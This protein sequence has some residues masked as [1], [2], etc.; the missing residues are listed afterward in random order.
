[1][2]LL[3]L[4]CGS[5]AHAKYLADYGYQITGVERSDSMIKMANAKNINGFNV[6]QGDITSFELPAKY[7]A[8]I[9]LF[10]VISYLTTNE[11]IKQCFEN[12]HAHLKDEGIFIF[13]VW[14]TP[15]VYFQKPETRIRRMENDACEITRIA[16]SD[17]N[18]E[19]NIVTV[20]FDILVKHKQSNLFSNFREV[21][22]MRHFSIPEIGLIAIQTGFTILTSEEFLTQSS[23]SVNTWGVC[24]VLKKTH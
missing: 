24:F 15:A 20:K 1:V 11:S 14:Y 17:M 16:E 19:A 22:P 4:G 6:I 3:E 2:Y 10:H 12:V 18:T 21:H 8:A 13:D 23:P 5:G 7:D 9:S